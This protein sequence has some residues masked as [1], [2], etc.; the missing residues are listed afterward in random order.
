M[1]ARPERQCRQ[2]PS[3]FTSDG[4]NVVARLCSLSACGVASFETSP[5]G[6]VRA[7]SEV[8]LSSSAV[9]WVRDARAQPGA[10]ADDEWAGCVWRT[11]IL[12]EELVDGLL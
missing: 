5:T 4:V 11:T 12:A 9:P 7:S 8:P 6:V 3:A 2:L 1:D 10:A